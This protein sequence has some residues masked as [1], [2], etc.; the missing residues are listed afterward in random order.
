[1]VS[2]VTVPDDTSPE[3]GGGLSTSRRAF[4]GRAAAGVAVGGLVWAAPSILTLDAAAAA[5]CGTGGTIDWSTVV[6]T[7]NPTSVTVGTVTAAITHTDPSG[8]G[9]APDFSINTGSFGGQSAPWYQL[10]I[11]NAQTNNLQ[12]VTFTFTKQ[13]N[14]LS[15]QFFDIDQNTTTSG[16]GRYRDA[17]FVSGV[18]AASTAIGTTPS[19][20]GANVNGLGT[21]ASPFLPL[22]GSNNITDGSGNATIT[23]NA[24]VMTVTITYQAKAPKNAAGTDLGFGGGNT[25]WASQRIGIGNLSWN[26][27]T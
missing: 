19:G 4:M 14:N 6:P 3:A 8:I 1:M 25:G 15:F 11:V 20:L 17:I 23:F 16:V 27:C 12:T 9:S 2:R 18:N 7:T 24:P 26:G 5:S 22:N 21:S 13:V 10:Q